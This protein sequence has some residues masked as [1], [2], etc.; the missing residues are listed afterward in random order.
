MDCEPIQI[1]LFAGL[2][3]VEAGGFSLLDEASSLK[4]AS[5]PLLTPGVVFVVDLIPPKIISVFVTTQ[6]RIIQ[7]FLQLF[8]APFSIFL[9]KPLF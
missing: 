1:H 6:I 9:W 7:L 3:H 2:I 8:G 4:S 5:V